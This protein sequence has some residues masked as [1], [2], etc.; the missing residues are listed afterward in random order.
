MA[1][2]FLLMHRYSKKVQAGMIMKESVPILRKERQQVLALFFLGFALGII[3]SNLW[4]N[5][6]VDDGGILSRWFLTQ[7]SYA[8]IQNTQLF[9]YVLE[10]RA[11]TFFLLTVVGFTGAGS[12]LLFACL[13]WSGICVGGF[14]SVCIMQ[15]GI[16]GLLLAV[17]SLFPQILLYVPLI[18]LLLKFTGN[19][20]EGTI[21]KCERKQ[22]NLA[23]VAILLLAVV[24][25]IAGICM[26]SYINPML[27]KKVIQLL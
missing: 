16:F 25:L 3:V 2:Y 26:E 1:Y 17:T 22:K 23:C 13:L 9:W 19:R 6:A 7:F 5:G 12:V 27:L 8:E 18:F 10:K 20:K 21:N 4:L 24:V 14:F 15:M 11:K